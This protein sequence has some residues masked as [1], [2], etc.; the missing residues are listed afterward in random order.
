MNK[1]NFVRYSSEQLPV[2]MSRATI[3]WGENSLIAAYVVDYGPQGMSLA[4]PSQVSPLAIPKQ[5]ETVKVLIPTGQVWFCGQCVYAKGESD[6][7]VS[8]G[9]YFPDPRDQKY[10]KDLLFTSLNVPAVTPAFVSYEWEELVEKMCD[11]PDPDLNKIGCHHRAN[12][13]EHK[14]R[15]QP[16]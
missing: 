2:S 8:M 10:L 14:G 3:S 9:V 5:Q 15:A 1:R 13:K 11:S 4:I 12:L 7:S 16:V 6:G